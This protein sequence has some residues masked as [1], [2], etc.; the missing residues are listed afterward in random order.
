MRVGFGY[1]AHRLE[2]GRPLI[3]GGVEIPHQA[4]LA[5]HSDADV[6]THALGDALLGAVAAGDL[7]RHFPDSDPTYRGISSLILLARIVTVVQ[8]RGYRP[9][10][11][12]V[13][14]V[15]EKP[16]LAPYVPQMIE[17]LAPILGLAPDAVSIKATSTEK[18][19]FAGR[20]EGIAAYAVVLVGREMEPL[21][22]APGL[23]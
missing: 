16:K 1:D 20:E 22:G 4:G 23:G 5:G 9:L 17:K 7:G 10:N 11:V 14:V 8:S 15:A 12:D 6:L 13:T 18:M 2:S 21:P 19:G 3:L